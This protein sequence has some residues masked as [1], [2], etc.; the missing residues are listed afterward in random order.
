MMTEQWKQ[1]KGY[2]GL[3][4]ISNH[5]R[6]RSFHKKPFIMKQWMHY[7]GHMFIHLNNMGRRKFFVHRLVALAFI[8]NPE[9]K[10]VVNHIDSNKANN[11]VTN[12]EWMTGAE[13]TRYYFEGRGILLDDNQEF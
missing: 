10:D 1:I 11:L 2:E 6:V 7:K 5:G 13:N 9:N 12:L 3:Y 8:P 4:E